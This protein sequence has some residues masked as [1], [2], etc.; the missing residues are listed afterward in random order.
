MHLV[1]QGLILL[2]LLRL[3]DDKKEQS[4]EL[5]RSFSSLVREGEKRTGFD[6]GKLYQ[7]GYIKG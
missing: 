4:E 3:K 5:L 7:E 1:E 6:A 2:L